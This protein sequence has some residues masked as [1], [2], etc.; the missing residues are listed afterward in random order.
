M[1]LTKIEAHRSVIDG[2]SANIKVKIEAACKIL[3]YNSTPAT[4]EDF[5]H[6]LSAAEQ[7][8]EGLEEAY[9]RMYDALDKWK[10]MLADH[11]DEEE[12]GTFDEK[13]CPILGM[14]SESED[15]LPLL[16]ERLRSLHKI[17]AKME[18]TTETSK[19]TGLSSPAPT[20]ISPTATKPR[21]KA[22]LP[23]V[24]QPNRFEQNP[25]SRSAMSKD[26]QSSSHSFGTALSAMGNQNR[27]NKGI[28]GQQLQQRQETAPQMLSPSNSTLL[29]SSSCYFCGGLHFNCQ[30]AKYP[31]AR[32]REDR[33][34]LLKR[35]T[36]CLGFHPVGAACTRRI[37]CWFC[38]SN[39]HVSA[40]CHATFSEHRTNHLDAR[41]Q[42]GGPSNSRSFGITGL[43]H[44]NVKPVFFQ[45]A[46]TTILNPITGKQQTVR[47]AINTLSSR[48]Y[49]REK[50]GKELDLVEKQNDKLHISVF[51]MNQS[52]EVPTPVVE[53]EA[54]VRKRLTNPNV[55]EQN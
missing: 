33:L 28:Q 8:L 14:L 4:V 41:G 12:H 5:E 52:V 55:S 10:L 22:Q 53:F 17:A 13:L 7:G 20:R 45:T 36:L 15:L 46:K 27:W 31:S 29:P 24:I 34:R 26:E 47:L 39:T 6:R 23:T 35:C 1:A 25:S 44:E 32:K 40:L 38:R 30:C 49:I 50:V 54:T 51:G 42:S 18:R 9:D 43:N 21:T 48:S 16:R 3:G 19:Q 2:Q 37:R 11:L